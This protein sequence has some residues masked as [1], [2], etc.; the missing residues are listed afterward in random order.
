MNFTKLLAILNTSFAQ[1]SF[2]ISSTMK[3]RQFSTKGSNTMVGICNNHTT[4]KLVAIHIINHTCMTLVGPMFITF[5]L[6]WTWL[7]IVVMRA[8]NNSIEHQ[9]PSER[10]QKHFPFARRNKDVNDVPYHSNHQS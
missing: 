8:P 10:F 6:M 9:L 2:S 7:K 5:Y 1:S 3:S 4:H